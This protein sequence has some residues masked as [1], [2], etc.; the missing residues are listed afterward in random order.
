[1]YPDVLFV[2]FVFTASSV[3][4]LFNVNA[5]DV[6]VVTLGMVVKLTVELNTLLVF[7]SDEE[8]MT[9]ML[10]LDTIAS[11]IVDEVLVANIVVEDILLVYGVADVVFTKELDKVLV[12][13]FD[14][15]TDV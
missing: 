9:E 14:T 13:G 15:V 10:L 4:V 11:F 8:I 7:A 5:L 1:M 2:G 12:S 6:M 3:L